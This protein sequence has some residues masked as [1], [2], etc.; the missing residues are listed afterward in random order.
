VDQLY[1]RVTQVSKKI[2]LQINIPE[3]P[4]FGTG[5]RFI[6]KCKYLSI[7][8][9]IQ[10]ITETKTDLKISNQSPIKSNLTLDYQTL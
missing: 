1:A 7:A 10:L 5:G 2:V 4:D 3:D 9:Q 8:M 6:F